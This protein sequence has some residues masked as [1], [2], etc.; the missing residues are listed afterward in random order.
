MADVRSRVGDELCL[1]GNLDAYEDL[2][3][4]SDEALRDEVG[5]QI[6]EGSVGGRRFV[7]SIGSPIMPDTRPERVGAF[8]HMS[9][10]VGRY[11]LYIQQNPIP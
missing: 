4:A 2:E 6:R 11:P 8:L 9:R 10:E 5:R 1:F 7:V 3:V